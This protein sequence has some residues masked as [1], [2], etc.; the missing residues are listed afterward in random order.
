MYIEIVPAANSTYAL[1]FASSSK[2]PYVRN[3]GLKV[4]TTAA[5]AMGA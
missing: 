4:G 3:W 5:A 1:Q 2:T